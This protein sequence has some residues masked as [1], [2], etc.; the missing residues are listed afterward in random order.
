[1][2]LAR[3]THVDIGVHLIFGLPDETPA[4]LIETARIINQLPISNVKLHNLH[5]LRNTELAQLYARGEFVP[6]ELE[7]YA[8]EVIPVLAPPVLTS[9]C[10][11]WPPWP[12]AGMS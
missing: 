2:R 6:D 3:H 12:V 9:P 1:M 7:A 10:S 4:R 8:D 5:V 11:A